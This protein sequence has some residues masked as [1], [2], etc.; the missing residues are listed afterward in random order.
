MG[1][2]NPTG[3]FSGAITPKQEPIPQA[4]GYESKAAGLALIGAHLLQGITQGRVAAYA[5]KEAQ[6]TQQIQRL[7]ELVQ[8]ANEN[9]AIPQEAKASLTQQYM[10]IMAGTLHSGLS[11]AVKGSDKDH[12]HAKLASGMKN[13]LESLTGGKMKPQQY[14]D[15]AINA[16]QSNLLTAFDPKNQVDPQKTINDSGMALTQIGTSLKSQ[17][18]RE[19]Y[20]EEIAQ[21]GQP[22]LMQ[23][24]KVDPKNAEKIWKDHLEGYD[25]RPK[26]TE[27][28]VKADEAKARLASQAPKTPAPPGAAPP[29]VAGSAPVEAAGS[30]PSATPAPPGATA[31]TT[32]APPEQAPITNDQWND[33]KTVGA[34]SK[35]SETV[36]IDGKPRKAYLLEANPLGKTPGWYMTDGTR[37]ANQDSV[38]I[39]KPEKAV[40]STKETELEKRDALAQELRDA[41]PKLGEAEAKQKASAMI[42]AQ[43][44]KRDQATKPAKLA[45]REAVE[46]ILAN[47]SKHAPTEV[48]AAKFLKNLDDVDL[49]KKHEDAAA[50]APDTGGP[51]QSYV[52][53]GK[54]VANPKGDLGI[55]AGAWE[56]INTGHVPYT[57]MAAGKG[58]SNFRENI[59][60]RA[61]ELLSDLGLSAAELPV[62]RGQIKANTAALGKVTGTGAMVQQFENTVESNMAT[63][64]KLSEKW[65]R[66]SIPAANRIAAAW[67]TGKGDSEALNF[68]AQMHALASEWAKVMSGATS[69][70]GVAVG[71][72][73]DAEAIMSPYLAK[74]QVQSLFDNV[75]KPDL[76][77]RS[78]A[79]DK[80]KNQLIKDIR[81]SVPSAGGKKNDPEDLRGLIK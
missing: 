42:V 8:S 74:G 26:R 51:A 71:N 12:P 66:T 49:L 28:E 44:D 61:G 80:E 10:T 29:Q 23:L 81:G 24:R 2:F 3:P 72:A 7:G 25:P 67:T 6:D 30:A 33:L 50:K 46:E 58:G 63:A 4:S 17:L 22:I 5:R 45:E 47:P 59:V 18:G 52:P 54:S 19:P 73:K 36:Y 9:P 78:K 20:K 48:S 43:Q 35:T 16:L 32:P 37:I 65:D 60:R 41:D 56:W 1:A 68:A 57:G 11:D 15:K 39:D 76:E 55:E 14:D 40:K 79:I 38:S 70:A 53:G 69:S 64:E 75:I 31:G 34:T 62:I 13:V 27:A 77:N 21:A